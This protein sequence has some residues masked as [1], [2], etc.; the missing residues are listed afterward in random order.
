[1]KVNLLEEIE[2]I[3]DSLD[4]ADCKDTISLTD[5]FS[6]THDFSRS[7]ILDWWSRRAD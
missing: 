6:N 5:S 1:M 3:V 2:D 4:M 7:T